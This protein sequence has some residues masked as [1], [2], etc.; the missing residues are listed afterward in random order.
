MG[1]HMDERTRA[2]C[3]FYRHPPSGSNI[4]PQ[5]FPKI[6]VLVRKPG[7]QRLKPNTI[8]KLVDTFHS[9]RSARG[10]KAG[11]RKTSPADDKLI[12]KTF[13]KVRQPLG[14][15]VDA[16]DVYN[17]LPDSLRTKVSPRTV[18]ERLKDK[19]YIM[20]EKIAKDD[21]GEAWRKKRLEFCRKHLSKS[22]T[23]WVNFVQAVGDF[24]YFTYYPRTL[25]R[26]YQVK[27]CKRTIVRAGERKNKAAFFKPRRHVFKRSEFKRVTKIKVF[28][29]TTSTG[30]SLVV[31]C[32]LYPV[33]QDWIKMLRRQVGPFL[34]NSFPHLK[35]RRMLLD[36][37]TILHTKDAKAAMRE[38]G[39]AIVPRWPAHSP[40]LNPQENVWAWAETHLRKKEKKND[41][42]ST[43][44]RRVAESCKKHPSKEVLVS[45]MSA[46]IA[47]CARRR[48]ANI[49]K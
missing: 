34:R 18:R 38:E 41:L 43:F 9:R 45:S 37:E 24:R 35:A 25:K 42:L 14:A 8:R 46:R 11:W 36:G 3:Y 31:P 32:P 44:K 49:G 23:Q 13:L 29:L 10:R 33:A 27:S 2:L 12:L 47:E 16:R 7:Q 30:Q 4:K 19:G 17:D 20:Q 40:D 26:R 15:R 39:L 48:G 1:I 21:M 6:A 5:T 28:G 22:G